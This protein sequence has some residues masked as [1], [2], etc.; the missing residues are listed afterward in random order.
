M[1]TTL[2]RG[3]EAFAVP[4]GLKGQ[5]S[6]LPLPDILQHLR[7]SAATGILSLVSGGARKALYLKDGPRRLRL[8]QSARTTGSARS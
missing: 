8:E 3:F 1:A 7:V 5:L 6:Q 2:P 4:G